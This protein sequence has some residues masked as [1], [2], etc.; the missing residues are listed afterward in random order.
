MTWQEIAAKKREAAAQKIPQAWRLPKSYTDRV[1]EAANW[2]VLSVSR[3][4]GILTEV[5]I[6]ITEGY[7]AVGL[8][9]EIALG[10]FRAEE[11][12]RAFCKR[13]AIAQQLVCTC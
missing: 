9:S 4:C 11:V 13:A 3:E 10:K 1:S 6:Q 12:A 7:D 2:N 5:E 8:L